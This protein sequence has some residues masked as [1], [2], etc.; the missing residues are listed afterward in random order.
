MFSAAKPQK[1][2]VHTISEWLAVE[3]RSPGQAQI[4]KHQLGNFPTDVLLGSQIQCFLSLNQHQLLGRWLALLC[5]SREILILSSY[6]PSCSPTTKF[7]WFESPCFSIWRVFKVC[8]FL[9]SILHVN[10]FS[11]YSKPWKVILLSSSPPYMEETEVREAEKLLQNHTAI[12][13]QR[14]IFERQTC[15][16]YN[17]TTKNWTMQSKNGQKT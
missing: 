11:P 3:V 5:P 10:L 12:I 17:S 15:L 7:Y 13:F 16:S 8:C 9:L 2:S 14:Q 1:S 4:S 6:P